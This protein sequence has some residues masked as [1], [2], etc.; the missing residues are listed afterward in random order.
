MMLAT[1]KTRE[2]VTAQIKTA[3]DKIGA[4]VLACLAVAIGAILLAGAAL[5]VSTRALRKATA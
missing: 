3:A 1:G 5:L 4:S 2:K